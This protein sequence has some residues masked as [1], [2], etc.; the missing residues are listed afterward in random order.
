MSRRSLL[1]ALTLGVA[2]A[3]VT[4]L[5]QTK[6]PWNAADRAAEA[7]RVRKEFLHAWTSYTALASGH[8]ELN[9]VS[10]TTHDW[11]PPAVFYMTPVDALDTMRLMGLNDEVKQTETL[12]LTH[13]SFD[14]D[15]SVQLFEINIRILGALADEY[16]ISRRTT[17]SFWRWRK[18]SARGFCPRSNRQRVCRIASSI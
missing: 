7:S 3:S 15:V 1:S 5:A 14:K 9:P 17:R 11:Y 4:V 18:I 12:L 6:A 2:L 13:L 8:D 10:K 16:Q